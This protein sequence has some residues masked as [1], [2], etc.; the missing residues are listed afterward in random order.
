MRVYPLSPIPA[1]LP[2]NSPTLGHQP[3]TGEKPSSPIDARQ[4]HPLLHMWLEP[5]VPPCVLL[6]WWFRSWELCLFGWY[7]CSS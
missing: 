6:G 2:S 7:C 3:F 1:S 5:W 4:D